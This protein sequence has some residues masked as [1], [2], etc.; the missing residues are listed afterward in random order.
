MSTKSIRRSGFTLI[1]LLVVIA[2]IAVLI[3]LLLPAVQQAR[4]AARRTQCKNNLKQLGLALHNYHDKYNVFPPGYIDRDSGTQV[5]GTAFTVGL[6]PEFDQAPLYNQ[7]TA[8]GHL[9]TNGLPVTDAG[10]AA[11]PYNNQLASTLPA[12]RCPSDVGGNLVATVQVSTDRSTGATTVDATNRFGRSNY[13]GVAG[14][15]G[16]L[17]EVSQTTPVTTSGQIGAGPVNTSSFRGIF[18]RNSKIGIRDMTDGTSNSV[19][20]GERYSPALETNVAAG[21]VNWA[22]CPNQYT[23]VGMASILGDTFTRING[24][25]LGGA[26]SRGQTTG[27][28]SMHTGG[29]H[30]LMGDGT[31]RFISDNIDIG[32][33]RYLSMVN[34]GNVIG[35]F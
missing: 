7:L 2:I 30:F 16:V 6:L 34:D 1:E 11:A 32:I 23:Q 29:C 8:S 13:P 33:L 17:T 4:E 3:A 18:G 28:G 21:H 10:F 25:N 27:F 20:V 35:E 15:A 22:A 31:V 19:V 12:L 26:G 14:W 5:I 24:N 9:V